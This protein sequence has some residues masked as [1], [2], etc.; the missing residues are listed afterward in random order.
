MVLV[1]V[2]YGSELNVAGFDKRGEGWEDTVS[3]QI[4]S[5]PYKLLVH[6]LFRVSWIDD[7][8]VLGGLICHQVGVV[9]ASAPP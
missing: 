9:V 1:S 7:H 6:L 2:H 4:S 8:G 3:G 5:V